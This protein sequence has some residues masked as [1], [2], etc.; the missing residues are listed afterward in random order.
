M[1]TDFDSVCTGST[2]V[3]AAADSDGTFVLRS[4]VKLTHA[5]RK[6]D[7]LERQALRGETMYKKVGL[8]LSLIAGSL[9]VIGADI[10]NKYIAMLGLICGQIGA[11]L[12][13]L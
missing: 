11:Y 12:C 13:V 7:S 10:G 1:A 9:V 5:I 2:P 6:S 8:I 4:V 3:R